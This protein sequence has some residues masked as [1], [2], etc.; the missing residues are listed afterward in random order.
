LNKEGFPQQWNEAIIVHI[1]KKWLT[2]YGKVT[3]LN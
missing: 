2:D 3:V 1:Y